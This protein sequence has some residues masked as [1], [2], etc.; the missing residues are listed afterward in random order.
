[1][2]CEAFDNYPPGTAKALTPLFRV[3][4]GAWLFLQAMP[5]TPVRRVPG[6]WGWMSKRPVPREIADGWFTPRPP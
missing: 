5:A 4:G 2:A 3:P 6:G 1:M